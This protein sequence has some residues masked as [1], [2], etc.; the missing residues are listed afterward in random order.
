VPLRGELQVLP[1]GVLVR[2]GRAV[3]HVRERLPRQRLRRVEDL[4]ARLLGPRQAEVLGRLG[5]Q[6]K[7]QKKRKKRK[8]RKKKKN[9]PR[10]DFSPFH[11]AT[12]FESYINSTVMNRI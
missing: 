9:A 8:K 7:N 4:L 2:V 3:L 10:G 5:F 1:R 6:E 12:I 11:N